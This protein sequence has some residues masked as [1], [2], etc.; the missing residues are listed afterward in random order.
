MQD[1]ISDIVKAALENSKVL[2]GKPKYGGGAGPLPKGHK[3]QAFVDPSYSKPSKSPKVVSEVEPEIVNLDSD[4]ED[5]DH[6]KDTDKIT[7]IDPIFSVKSSK[8]SG[9][10]PGLGDGEDTEKVKEKAEPSVSQ[11]NNLSEEDRQRIGKRH[12]LKKYYQFALNTSCF[13]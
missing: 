11:K 6:K 8:S 3:D 5:D 4:D 1:S 13:W 2:G 7:T 9:G 10:I 12:A